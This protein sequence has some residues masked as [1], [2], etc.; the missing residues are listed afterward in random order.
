MDRFAFGEN[1]TEFAKR[2]RPEDYAAAKES[3]RQ[4][5]PDL[6]GRT[7]LDIGSGSGLFSA[8]ASALGARKV[9][10]FDLDPQ[11]VTAAKSLIHKIAQW[12]RDVRKDV[13][14]F[15]VESILNEGVV[16]EQFDIVYSWGVLHHT[17]DMYKAFEAAIKLVAQ[18]G[19]LV[20]A[21]YNKHFT[22]PI[23]K[24]IKFTYVKSPK[25]AKNVIVYPILA[26]KFLAA[27]IISRRNPL[28]R[29]RGMRFYTD[30]VDWVGGYPYQYASASE[31][32]DFFGARG[33]RLT[34][35]NKTKGCT[36]CNEFVLEKVR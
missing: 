18:K 36:G 8:A 20:I 10:G 2:L 32:S 14:E 19:T 4:L 9:V 16:R 31:V 21:I 28:K 12:D 22:S 23:W 6:E 33:F 7:F 1:W 25:F 34:K 5:I 13:I 30:I 26:V 24:M 29:D 15:R 11:A 35:F 17:G 3:L 27:V